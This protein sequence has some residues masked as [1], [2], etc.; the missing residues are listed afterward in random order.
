[1]LDDILCSF[2]SLASFTV[3]LFMS[4]YQEIHYSRWYFLLFHYS[5]VA[6]LSHHSSFTIC[7][8]ANNFFCSRLRVVAVW[9]WLLCSGLKIFNPP[10]CFGFFKIFLIYFQK[11][12]T[13]SLGISLIVF[14][15]QVW[16]SSNNSV[17]RYSVDLWISSSQI[18]I[19]SLYFFG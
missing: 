8:I 15:R 14:W 19:F 5:W 17:M 12:Y 10:R 11:M 18:L 1:M 4:C 13:C 7:C 16:M 2:A 3:L 9:F 6:P